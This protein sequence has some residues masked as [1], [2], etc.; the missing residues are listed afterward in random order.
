VALLDLFLTRN[1]C[2]PFRDRYGGEA[3][4]AN[5]SV[6]GVMTTT[7]PEVEADG[8]APIVGDLDRAALDKL[9]IR[10]VPHDEFPLS[11]LDDEASRQAWNQARLGEPVD[12]QHVEEMVAELQ[13]G[14]EFPP[15]IFY[16]DD[17]DRCVTLSGN[18]R[19]RAFDKTNHETIPAYEATGLAGL[20]KEDE[21]VLR[22]IYEANH[23]H[24]K[25][26]ASD[27]RVHQALALVANGYNVRAAAAAVGIPE[28]RVRDEYDSQRAT[29]RLEQELGVDTSPIPIS[30]QRRLVN[31]RNDKVVQAA[32]SVVPLMTKKTQE[33]NE[34]V[35]A[36]NEE[37]TEDAQLAVVEEFAEAVKARA[38]SPAA[39]VSPKGDGL[40]PEVR[41][42]DTAVGSILRFDVEALRSGLPTEYRDRLLARV[43]EAAEQLTAAERVL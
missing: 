15:I 14:V 24:G 40:A 37:R 35:K 30:A 13:R 31:I 43:K 8:A 36:V 33:V 42:F 6:G 26:V 22:L 17:R 28:H 21:R 23:G 38:A 18:H 34:L 41:R 2:Q 5:Q 19:R 4:L 32:A 29:T 10:Y 12:E 3:F 7:A 39:K 27:D 11:D 9:G 1:A 20:R 25:Q 16:R